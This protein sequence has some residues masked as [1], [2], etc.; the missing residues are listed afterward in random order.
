MPDTATITAGTLRAARLAAGLSLRAAAKKAETSHAA[1]AAYE[2]GRK[3]PTVTTYIRLV[4]AY[5]YAADIELAPRI[6]E[7][8]GYSRSD[9]L[10]AVLELAEQF[11]ARHERTLAYPIFGSKR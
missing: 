11:P 1:V 2:Q 5:G 9:E 4:A 8:D 3:A 6:R 7:V 10:L